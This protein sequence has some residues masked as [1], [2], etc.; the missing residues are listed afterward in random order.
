MFWIFVVVAGFTG[1]AVF[2]NQSFSR[3]ADSPITTTIE[4]LPISRLEFP[5]VT[6]CPP[7]K[8][9]TNLNLDI[10][11]SSKIS[12][13]ERQMKALSEQISEVV[14]TSNMESK[15]ATYN[16]YEEKNRYRKQYHGLSRIQ[17]PILT[18]TAEMSR[19]TYEGGKK[20]YP[21]IFIFNMLA[22]VLVYK[23][24]ILWYLKLWIFVFSI[25]KLKQRPRKGQYQHL[26]FNNHLMKIHSNP[27]QVSIFISMYQ[28]AFRKE[29]IL[30]IL[31]L[32]S[33]LNLIWRSLA[34]LNM[35]Q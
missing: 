1:A 14:F 28:R 17:L 2:I 26:P 25:I 29:Q 16:E 31:V 5:N 8:S 23:V 27:D 19:I 35:S 21:N 15:L 33:M 6:V 32:S 34:N 9:F 30:L 18:G 22:L 11:R 12:L 7:R 20:I 13:S 10:A 24:F 3:W 4:T